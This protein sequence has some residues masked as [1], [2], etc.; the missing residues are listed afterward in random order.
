MCLTIL[1]APAMT[2]ADDKDYDPHADPYDFYSYQNSP[3]AISGSPP[4]VASSGQPYQF[5]PVVSDADGDPLSFAAVNLPPWLTL[6][7]STGALYGTPTTADIGMHDT[8]HLL[9][10]DGR[11]SASLGPFA[12]TVLQ[13]AGSYGGQTPGGSPPATTGSVTLKWLPPKA[14]KNGSPLLNLAGFRI[15]AGRT[16]ATMTLRA[17]LRNPRLTRHVLDSL[18]TGDWWFSMTAYD[19]DWLESDQSTA[20]MK[21][22]R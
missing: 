12:I 18:A 2:S 15:Y 3:P 8:I 16:P 7:R 11:A 4:A 10:S 6:D 20:V 1:A 9:V 21:S 13:G 14:R 5:A 19:A 17:D 22:V